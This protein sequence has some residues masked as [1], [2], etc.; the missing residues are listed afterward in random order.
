MAAEGLLAQSEVVLWPGGAASLT[1]PEG[2][3]L[4]GVMSAAIDAEPPRRVVLVAHQ[5][6]HVPTAF[7]RGSGQRLASLVDIRE[8][9]RR[10]IDR[11]QGAFGVRPET[12][13]LTETG[14]RR[15][16]GIRRSP[17]P[18]LLRAGS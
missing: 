2:N 10:S 1:G 11:V 18:D 8:R 17:Q 3:L 15:V 7:G 14:A 13:Y 4:L 9:R 6:C 5:D 12:W 16:G